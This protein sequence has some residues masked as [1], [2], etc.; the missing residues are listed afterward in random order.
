[1]ARFALAAVTFVAGVLAAGASAE[2][3]TCD[4][5]TGICKGVPGAPHGGT[6]VNLVASASK[7]A[8]L[9]SKVGATVELS[10]RQACD[11][12]LMQ[13]GGFSPLTGFM[14]KGDYES[15]VEKMRLESGVLMGLPVILDVTDPSIEGKMVKL[16]YKGTT[17]AVMLA[18][19]VY[20]PNKVKEAKMCYGT[21]STEHPSTVELFSELGKYYM[22]GPVYGFLEGF[23][24]V[25]G[26]GFKTPAEV[27]ATL[28]KGKEVVAFQ[29]RNPVHKA[30]FELL[31]TAQEDVK[32]SIIFVHPTCGPTQPGDIDGPTRIKTY[33]VL[34]T[35]EGYKKWAGDNFRW[36]YLPYSMKMAGPREAIQ[37]MIIRKNFGATYFI[38]GRDMA[39]TKSTLTSDDFYGAFEAQDKGKEHSEE[40]GVKVASYPNMVYVGEK[41]NER[42]YAPDTK[43]KE[44]GIKPQKLSGT[45]F[46]K[47]L[48]S[49]EE[50]PEWFAFPKVVKVL[51]DGGDKI[52]L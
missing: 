14:K 23:E 6:L 47:R 10:E 37:H 43:A 49:G 34:Q 45:E 28:P 15:V 46:R 44:M 41:G 21:S 30:H 38:I 24:G 39:G 16:T 40:L 2:E 31:V 51:R 52:F 13:Y 42:G 17:M 12:A 18:E 25:W 4:A 33:E 3:G 5:K 50:I 22:G 36:A 35:E 8:E 19:E 32:D 29:N 11:V 7:Q 1:M 48:R 26:A 9:L 20:K 27:R